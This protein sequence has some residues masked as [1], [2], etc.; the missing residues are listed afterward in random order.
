MQMAIT[1]E[2]G[3]PSFLAPARC[4]LGWVTAEQGNTLEGLSM[5]TEGIVAL[6]SLDH[7]IG[8]MLVNGLMSDALAWSGRKS[9]A[10]AALDEAL[11]LSAR[12]GAGWLDAE[13]HRRKAE[14]LITGSD[15]DEAAAEGHFRKAI[16][17]ACGQSAKLIE[18]RA[19][20]GLAR[21]WRGQGREAEAHALLAR[22]YFWFTEGFTTPDMTEA[23]ELLDAL[24]TAPT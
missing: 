14:L 13:L 20:I 15:R 19:G 6:A 1:E 3:L 17:I 5:L 9:D 11:A 21:L 2:Q 18:L 24:A 12:T 23:R 4:A 10:V 8:I 16:D 7:K 22:I